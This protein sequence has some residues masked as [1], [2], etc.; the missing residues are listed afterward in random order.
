M[1]PRNRI[2][3]FIILAMSIILYYLPSR[4]FPVCGFP[5]PPGAEVGLLAGHACSKTLRVTQGLAGLTFI[6]GLAALLWTRPLIAW[7]SSLAAAG[8]GILVILTPLA[9]APVCKMPT[10]SCRLGTLPALVS[11]GILLSAVGGAGTLLLWKR[12]GRATGL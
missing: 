5:L 9:I 11:F 6:L 8:L 3:G 12:H 1:L 7:I 2:F 10:M 4:L